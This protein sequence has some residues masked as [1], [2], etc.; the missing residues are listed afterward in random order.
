MTGLDSKIN[1]STD[2]TCSDCSSFLNWQNNRNESES[3]KVVVFRS[4]V[5]TVQYQ[6]ALDDSLEAKAVKFLESVDPGYDE[7]TDAHL[8][9]FASFIDD[10]LRDFL[11][12]IVV[13]ISSGS[14]A[15]STA[16][17]KMLESLFLCSRHVHYTLIKANLI[18]QLINTLNPQSLSFAEAV[19]IH[20]Y[21]MKVITN[22]LE[23]ATPYSL[24]NIGMKYDNER[25]DV[26]ETNEK[27]TQKDR[28]TRS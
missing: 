14:Q 10:S 5:A 2:Y 13:L 6:P 18:P 24:E 23:L 12:S 28:T 7:L 20:I 22:S 17:M 16:A 19:D 3:E 26:H 21:L 25:R 27:K 9:S 8:G 15:I 1:A 11:H 4:L